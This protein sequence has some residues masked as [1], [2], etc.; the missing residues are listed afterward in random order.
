MP[1]QLSD[2]DW[3]EARERIAEWT[4]ARPDLSVLTLHAAL[5][6]LLTPD[7]A[8]L[9]RVNFAPDAADTPPVAHA[10]LLLSPVCRPVNEGMYEMYPG[11]RALLLPTLGTRFP[12]A[13]RAVATLLALYCETYTT[14][15]RTE[16][17]R[18]AQLVSA[19]SFLDP[20]GARVWLDNMQSDSQYDSAKNW[21]LAVR[22]EIAGREIRQTSNR[23]PESGDAAANADIVEK[24][25]WNPQNL[26]RIFLSATQKT[27]ENDLRQ[28]RLRLQ[29]EFGDRIQLDGW[30]EQ[31]LRPEGEDH[32][33]AARTASLFILVVASAYGTGRVETEYRAAKAAGVP[34]RVFFFGAERSAQRRKL[35]DT[36]PERYFVKDTERTRQTFLTRW[37]TELEENET[38]FALL[39]RNVSS[40]PP[41]PEVVRDF[42]TVPERSAPIKSEK[43]G[44]SNERSTASSNENFK[45][46]TDVDKAWAL[47][48]S[49]IANGSTL[50]VGVTERVK[51]GLVVDF[52][53]RGFIP[54]SHRGQR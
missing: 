2:E 44:K 7:L 31:D 8:Y 1:L 34:L 42:L 36:A 3:E 54:A 52:G 27:L 5:P 18:R 14:A 50:Q 49:A 6:A 32:E 17:L 43:R 12:T 29:K 13:E 22:R 45:R 28:I 26:P 25:V 11:V 46:Q 39:R 9:I 51:G 21:L 19:Y 33:A 40:R 41:S 53:L 15:F 38:I 37:K 23:V 35:R 47:V 24:P 16:A 30:E 48:E 4:A 10:D 20:N